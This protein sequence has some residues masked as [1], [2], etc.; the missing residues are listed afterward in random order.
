MEGSSQ[1]KSGLGWVQDGCGRSRFRS[2]SRSRSRC[3]RSSGFAVLLLLLRRQA[4]GLSKRQGRPTGGG[5]G[6]KRAQ[7]RAGTGTGT[8][9]SRNN[10]TRTHTDH[11]DNGPGHRIGCAAAKMRGAGGR[12]RGQ[13]GLRR[14]QLL[15]GRR[16]DWQTV[17]GGRGGSLEHA[18]EWM[19]MGWD[20]WD[21]M[22]LQDGEGSGKGPVQ[23]WACFVSHLGKDGL[24]SR[25]PA[26][27]AG[28]RSPA[29]ELPTSPSRSRSLCLSLARQQ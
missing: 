4:D 7:E 5:L 23:Q 22:G 17:A 3:W 10:S 15:A 18:M 12:G 2:R 29:H 9:S 19:A 26:S 27:S 11:F 21:G 25:A 13:A 6:Q 16:A 20:G 14:Q 1:K 24:C 8:G 28:G